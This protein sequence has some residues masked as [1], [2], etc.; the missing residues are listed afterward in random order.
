MASPSSSSSP[1]LPRLRPPL[2][3]K[4][5]NAQKHN[6]STPSLTLTKR[7]IVASA[8]KTTIV[9]H[10]SI[11]TTTITTSRMQP[12]D[13]HG[14]PRR[15]LLSTASAAATSTAAKRRSPLTP[16]VAVKAPPSTAPLVARRPPPPPPTVRTSRGDR[17]GI[18]SSPSADGSKF[19]YA[20]DAAPSPNPPPPPPRPL[21]I[22]QRPVSFRYAD[23]R[24]TASPPSAVGSSSSSSSKFF[25]ANGLPDLRAHKSSAVASAPP[26]LSSRVPAAA[27]PTAAHGVPL[28]ASAHNV[29]LSST[30]PDQPQTSYSPHDAASTAVGGMRVSVVDSRLATKWHARATIDVSSATR[31]AASSPPQSPPCL[32]PALA[33]AS[34]IQAAEE[35]R[36]GEA[37]GT[38]ISP[39]KSSFSAA[40]ADPISELVA[41]ARRERKVQDLEITNASLEA[42]NRTLERQLR[43]QTAEL[44]RYRHDDSSD[45]D[46]LDARRKRDERRL[47]L[48]LSKHRDLL[49]DSQKMN[50][51]I[52]RCLD[53]TEMLIKDGQKALAYRVRPADVSFGGRVL[54]PDD[55]REASSSSLPD[56]GDRPP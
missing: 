51:S 54:G 12:L 33:M 40:A 4:D 5:C 18:R 56:R 14:P 21:S 41:N 37:D 28:S 31:T 19:F 16:K 7:S 45:S 29:S 15:P 53:W 11:T 34:L 3:P 25:Y 24:R 46:R 6:A 26:A 8:A 48:D 22:P 10:R 42:I 27:P 43:K 1:R 2:R 23:S 32:S 13:H 35:A 47:Q 39:T 50:Q 17:P 52:K 30:P 55:E 44:R 20:R 38:A 49:V 9:A 36:D